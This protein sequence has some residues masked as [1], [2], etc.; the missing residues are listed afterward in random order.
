MPSEFDLIAQY[1]SNAHQGM[2]PTQG[3]GDDCALVDPLGERLAVTTDMMALG[4][5]FL[6]EANPEDVGH[7]ALAVNLSDL[8]AA[9]AEPRAFLLSLGLPHADEAWVAAFSRGLL[10]E[11]KT[12]GCALIGGDTTRTPLVGTTHAPVTMSITALGAVSATHPLTRAGAQVGDDVWVSG[13]PGD[14]FVALGIRLE[15][16]TPVAGT[17]AYLFSRMDR[18]TPRVALGV[19]LRGVASACAD[20]SDG[21]AA[22]LGHILER[23]GVGAELLEEK[24]PLSSALRTY[25][26]ELALKAALTGGDDYELVFTASVDRRDAII[27][28]SQRL[29]LPLTRLGRVTPRA[30]GDN[31][32]LRTKDGVSQPLAGGFDHFR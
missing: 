6:P 31:L 16:I 12:Y 24:V 2:W 11:A 9:G 5:H 8:A 7:K 30:L 13:T 21:L 3:V 22:D 15:T 23:S 19:A 10:E 1:F 14:A 20:V 28:L 25:P 26:R 18:P 29:G 32:R 27:A 17:E 4:T